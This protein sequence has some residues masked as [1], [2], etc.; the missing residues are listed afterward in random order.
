MD[1]VDPADMICFLSVKKDGIWTRPYPINEI[2]TKFDE[3]DIC[4]LQNNAIIFASDRP[5]GKGGL[6]LY[7][8]KNS[9]QINENDNDKSPLEISAATTVYNIKSK[10]ICTYN[11]SLVYPYIYANSKKILN[12]SMRLL[13]L[14][15][16]IHYNINLY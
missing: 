13:N 3:S 1:L 15:I 9:N 14:K 4:V 8:Y 6:D 7:Y 5:G 2:N 10:S 16:A 12:L 11:Y